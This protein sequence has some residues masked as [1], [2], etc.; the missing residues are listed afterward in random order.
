MTVKA[1]HTA[2]TETR[3]G[4]L[5]EVWRV[6]GAETLRDAMAAIPGDFKVYWHNQ[7]RR[8]FDL[9]VVRTF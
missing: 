5:A 8:D 7:D 3:T 6:E 9:E 4:K 2:D 1:T